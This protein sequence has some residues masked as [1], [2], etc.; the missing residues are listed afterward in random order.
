MNA[1]SLG[2]LMR[3]QAQS[4]PRAV[5]MMAPEGK[6]FREISYKELW[7][8]LRHYASYLRKLG[9]QRGQRV[10]IIS[11]NCVE[12]AMLDWSC[13]SL[14]IATVPVYPTLTPDS[15]H[16]IVENCDAQ[17]I[18]GTE[19]QLAKVASNPRRKIVLR[20]APESLSEL[21]LAETDL[22]SEEDWNREIDDTKPRDLATIIYT[23]GTTGDPKGAML[24]HLNFLHVCEEFE[25]FFRFDFP[26]RT[27]AFLPMSHIFERIVQCVVYS[28]AGCV[29]Y[30]KNLMT[31]A[32]DMQTVKP[33]LLAAVPRF[34]ENLRDK[35]L[36]GVAKQSPVKQTIFRLGLEQGLRARTGKFAP[37]AGV[38]D[39]L[40]GAKVRERTGGEIR[41]IISG[42]AALAPHVAEFFMGVGLTVLQGYGLTETTGGSVVNHPTRNKYW[43]V[44]EPLGLD[45]KLAEDGEILLRGDGIML[46]YFNM[47][48]ETAKAI[49]PDGWF[50]TGDIGAM[51]GK[52]LKI[53]DRKKDILV[54]A[55]GKNIAPQPIENKLKG[56]D[57]IQE[58]V[59]LGDGMDYV[60]A[61]IIPRF[62]QV[63][64][65]LGSKGI[66]PP[67]T[68]A[69]LIDVA[70]VKELLQNEIRAVNKGLANFET[71]KKHT[72]LARAFTIDSGEL[73]PSGKVK[74]KVIR[75]RYAAEIDA[76]K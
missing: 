36:D 32:N 60:C 59:L 20:G 69:E 5:A 8:I 19:D 66:K 22:I 27:V 6:G 55:N 26:L 12:W 15:V 56:S 2:D 74:R 21:A 16:Y 37:L 43:T 64:T 42:G 68:D 51:D 49:D 70:E 45:L 76:M 75:E 53:T 48:E 65:L 73:T 54:L 33:T 24:C 71:V 47:P 30:S 72:L 35:V 63:K 62:D 46:G 50:H 31:L 67:A 4:A 25:V 7:S 58:A 41:F 61:L 18:V 38:L 52:Q 14:G 23:S 39:K 29:A 3:K 17:L 1:N 9:I 28:R 34:L 40:V 11:E 13:Q 10:A 44:G 57:Y